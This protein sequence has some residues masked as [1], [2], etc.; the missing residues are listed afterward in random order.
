M[1]IAVTGSTGLI[2]T[3]LVAALRADGQQVTR[4]VRRSPAS[5]DEI[6]WDPRAPAGGVAAGALDDLDAVIHLAGA[7]VADHR[8]TPAYQEEIRASRVVGTHALAAALAAARTPPAVLLSGSA[9]GWYG[10]TGGREVDETAPAGQ[11]F[12]A[13]VVRGWE[14]AAEP[15]RQ[16]GVR[17]V[18]MRSGIVL[19]RRGG[20][21]ARM[22]V[23][24]RLGLGSRLGPGTQVMSWIALADH[25]GA[26]RFLLGRADISGPV[27]LTAPHP[28]TNAEFTSALAAALHRPARLSVPAPALRLALGGVT[29]DLLSSARVRPRRL[30]EAGY[31]FQFPDLAAAL[32]A[33]LA[34]PPTPAGQRHAS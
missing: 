29:S 30:A 32:A 5:P 16:V 3:A 4:L 17:V 2:G 6:A 26:V 31:Q 9:I 19:S 15:A 14:A 12:L 34:G 24:F 13:D 20:V 18:T 25:L 8:W 28:V 22:L 21:L 11:G 1:R 23:P 33:E 27:N 10:D 7:G